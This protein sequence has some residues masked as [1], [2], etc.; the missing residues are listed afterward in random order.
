MPSC[1]WMDYPACVL[2]TLII[3]LGKE[4]QKFL[5]FV[6]SAAIIF[7]CVY[8][9]CNAIWKSLLLKSEWRVYGTSL[10]FCNLYDA[11]IIS[12]KSFGD[13]DKWLSS[14]DI[15]YQAQGHLKYLDT[16][17][18][19]INILKYVMFSLMALQFKS[20]K[21][22]SLPLSHCNCNCRASNWSTLC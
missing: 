3:I 4:L 15:Y 12:S 6:R 9:K 19:L 1:L 11:T 10:H 8:I 16:L 2:S 17:L 14:K 7:V 21:V 5:S 13:S 22:K 20:F 18:V